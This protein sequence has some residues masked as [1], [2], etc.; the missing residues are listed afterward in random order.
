VPL[1]PSIADYQIMLL[2][3]AALVLVAAHIHNTQQEPTT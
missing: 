3:L 1:T 2:V